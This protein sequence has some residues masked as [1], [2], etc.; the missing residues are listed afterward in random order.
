MLHVST[1]SPARNVS[2]HAVAPASNYDVIQNQLKS[3]FLGVDLI[4][5]EN[6]PAISTAMTVQQLP[7]VVREKRLK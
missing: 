6:T 2:S 5:V 1:I 3:G 7:I 4:E